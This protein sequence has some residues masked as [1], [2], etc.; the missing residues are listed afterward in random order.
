MM[1]KIGIKFGLQLLATAILLFAANTGGAAPRKPQTPLRGYMVL[2]STALSFSRDLDWD[3]TEA[4]LWKIGDD[5]AP[6][7]IDKTAMRVLRALSQRCGVKSIDFN[8]AIR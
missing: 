4:V 6:Y 1:G 2:E 5:D 8:G 3:G 7:L